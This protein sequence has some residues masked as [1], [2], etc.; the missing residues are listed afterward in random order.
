MTALSGVSSLLALQAGSGARNT[1]IATQGSAALR[2]NI[3]S[4]LSSRAVDAMEPLQVSLADGITATGCA[5]CHRLRSEMAQ[6][7]EIHD[8]RRHILW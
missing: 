3:V 6:P 8:F 4:V 5:C 7:T 2:D 1:V